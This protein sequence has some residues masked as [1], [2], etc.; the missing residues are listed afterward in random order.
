ME[1]GAGPFLAWFTVQNLLIFAATA[2]HCYYS[3]KNFQVILLIDQS[4]AVANMFVNIHI[5]SAPSLN[6]REI[7]D[8]FLKQCRRTPSFFFFFFFFFF[9]PVGMNIF[10]IDTKSCYIQ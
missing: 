5:A 7:F 3:L 4:I 1:R 8:A 2:T 10:L 6:C 9:P